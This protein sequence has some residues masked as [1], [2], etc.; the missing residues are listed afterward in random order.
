MS[1]MLPLNT[2]LLSGDTGTLPLVDGA[3]DFL[4]I[5]SED[6]CAT[7]VACDLP[8]IESAHDLVT[9]TNLS[10]PAEIIPEIMHLGTKCVIASASKIGKTWILLDLAISVATGTKFLK[11]NTNQGRVL[12]INF[13][14]QQSFLTQRIKTI[15][16]QKNLP[17]I[18]ALDIWTLR[19]CAPGLDSLA[20]QLIERTQGEQYSL[21][22][23]DPIYK[24]M[25]GGSENAAGGV[26][27]LCNKLDQI[28]NQTGAAVV[29]VHHFS[30][31]KQNKKTSMDRMSGSGVFARDADT[32][33][34]LTAHQETNCYA[35]ELT[36]RNFPP[37]PSFVVGWQYPC[38]FLRPELDPADLAGDM[39]AAEPGGNHD[40]LLA[41][42]Q[43]NPMTKTNWQKAAEGL[44]ISRATFYRS[45]KELNDAG[46][47]ELDE[48]K[49]TWA[50]VKHKFEAMR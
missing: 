16:A 28:A 35:V 24:L 33:I 34:T 11:W 22:I 29:Y 8:A 9:D 23:L 19:G 15:L 20:Q 6:S 2:N 3:D 26:G 50:I 37:Q 7:E 41:L 4:E 14:I 45:T 18:G 38:M 25:A 46:L 21:I 31:G 39:A 10:F 30:K 44:G 40:S 1:T 13:E 42:L 43:D 17:S 36:L 32:I 5:V 49:G 27:A 47:V 48:D 12:Y